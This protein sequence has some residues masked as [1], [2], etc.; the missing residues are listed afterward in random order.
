MNRP[1]LF[2][3]FLFSA[4]FLG[5]CGEE[6][7]RGTDILPGLALIDSVDILFFRE[8]EN[9]RFYTYVSTSDPALIRPLQVNCGTAIIDNDNCKKE[10]KIYCYRRGNIITTL[11]Y[12]YK[13]DSCS[14]L[15]FIK[16]GEL[17]S[18]RLEEGFIRQLD[19]LK[20]TAVEPGN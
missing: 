6:V 3:G 1:I 11:Y 15:R 10:G 4:L 17:Y 7:S 5:S 13:D 18:M 19:G 20:E 16:N 8:P 14:F 12:G 2:Y 9:Q